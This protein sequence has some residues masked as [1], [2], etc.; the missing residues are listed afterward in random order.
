MAG[1]GT[2]SY[3][4]DELHVA[5]LPGGAGVYDDGDTR[6]SIAADGSG[7]YRDGDRRYTVRA[8]GSGVYDDGEVRVWVDADGAG[9]YQDATTRLSMDAEG[10]VFG[11]ASADQVA[12]VQDVLADGLPPFPPVPAITAVHPSG[13]CAARSSGWTRTCRSTWTARPCARGARP[14]HQVAP[15]LPHSAH[16]GHRSTGTPTTSATRRTTSTSRSAAPA[17]CVTCWWGGVDEGS[18]ETRGF[19]ETHRCGWKHPADTAPR[20]FVS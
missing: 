11:D 14:D 9:G 13:R 12:A 6:L 15:L 19:G 2:G 18:L 5:V 3:D 20:S 8:D 4:T 7:T 1:D 16:R 10:T 17:R